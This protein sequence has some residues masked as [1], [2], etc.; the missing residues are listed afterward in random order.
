MLSRFNE[1]IRKIA[2]PLNTFNTV[3]G[4]LFGIAYVYI[5]FASVFGLILGIITAISSSAMIWINNYFTVKHTDTSTKKKEP[6]RKN[7]IKSNIF[8]AALTPMMLLCAAGTFFSMYTGTLLLAAALAIPFPPAVILILAVILASA[9]AIGTLA[10]S[11]LMTHD[12]WQGLR[13]V[14]KKDYEEMDEEERDMVPLLEVEREDVYRVGPI[15][16]RQPSKIP[17]AIIKPIKPSESQDVL[18]TRP[19][20]NSAPLP[21]YSNT[22]NNV[23]PNSLR[24]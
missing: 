11:W 22:A 21:L 13:G 23:M 4:F 15:P 17:T 5:P 2:L 1:F 24:K 16:V 10:N 8:L 7:T 20:A 19:R 14:V 6:I 12:I 9:F 18:F 3:V